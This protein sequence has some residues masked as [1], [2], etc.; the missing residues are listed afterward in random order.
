M[1]NLAVLSIAV[2]L[3][4]ALQATALIAGTM[5]VMPDGSGDAPTI[6]AGLELCAAGDTVLVAAGTYYENLVW[7]G[8]DGIVLMSESGPDVTTIDGGATSRVITI[9]TGVDET[10]TIGG[11]TIQNGYTLNEAGAGILCANGSAPTIINNHITQNN[12]AGSTGAASG[13]GIYCNGSSPA[14]L[15]NNITHNSGI[16]G[17]G[18]GCRY[19]SSPVIE[20]NTITDNTA[21]G[22]MSSSGGGIG[23][24]SDSNPI[25]IRNTIARNLAHFAA[26]GIIFVFR[27]AGTIEDNTIANNQSQWGGGIVCEASSP[28]IT[29]NLITANVGTTAGG[30]MKIIQI[31]PGFGYSYLYNNEITENTSNQGAGIYIE[32]ASPTIERCTIANN[33]GDGVLCSTG[34]QGSSIPLITPYNYIYANTGYGVRNIDPTVVIDAILNWW[35]DPSG[36][37]HPTLNPDG[38]GNQVS[39][40]VLFDPF[41][42]F[43]GVGD[44]EP[45]A[46]ASLA[47]NYP[48]PFNP[49]TTIKFSLGRPQRAR[50]AVYDLT[51]QLLGVLADRRY[52][53]GDHSVFWN[54]RD[55][56]GRALPSGTYIVRLNTETTR[57]A[58]KVMLLR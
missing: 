28:T 55:A 37:Y 23:V 29:G 48:N 34:D 22:E 2:I 54:G 36:P 58:R 16:H 9:N 10:T 15:N 13:G 3:F 8:V 38:F 14:I 43:T 18:I 42:I 1:K 40:Y 6:Q 24:G 27:C 50:V 33:F 51:G 19:G 5:Y 32:G 41:S 57:Q 4:C 53:T 12:A 25:V 44:S 47:Q 26:G 39:D 45:P 52:D 17:G 30:G 49:Q 46:A 21:F 20:S 56:E 35:G 11:F 7:P 31:H